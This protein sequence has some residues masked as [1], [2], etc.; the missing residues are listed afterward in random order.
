MPSQFFGL[1]IAYT[2]LLASNAALNTTSNNISNATTEGYSRQIVNQSAS[3]ALRTYTTYGCAGSGVDVNS[4]DRVRDVF[5]D[6][7]YWNNNSNVGKFSILD[8]YT[9]QIEDYFKDDETTEGFNTIFDKMVSNL[10]ELKKNAGDVPTKQQFVGSAEGLTYYFNTMAENLEKL[11]LEINTQIQNKIDMINSYAAEIAS[12]NKQINV[13]ELTG[14][15]ANELRDKRDS[16]LD[17]LSL[18][19]DVETEEI[20]IR[21]SN[22]LDRETGGNRYIVKIAGGQKLVDTNE[23]YELVCEAKESY[24]TVNQSDA[25]GLYDIYFRDGRSFNIYSSVV[26]GEL[27]GLIEM[28]DGNNGEN[29]TG[30]VENVYSGTLPSGDTRTMIDVS[31]TADY[32]K[33]LNACILSPAGGVITLGNEVYCYDKFSVTYDANGEIE[34]YTFVI[35]NDPNK[36]YKQPDI[37]RIGKDAT[38]GKSVDYQ[39]I[40]Y[41]QEQLNEW[42]RIFAE[43]FNKIATTPGAEDGEGNPA[44]IFFQ[45][46]KPGDTTQYHFDA[47]EGITAGSVLYSTDDSYFLLTAKN[48]AVSNRIVENAN[49]FATHT[50]IGAGQ[51][52]YDIVDSLI[53]MQEDTGVAEFRGASAGEF[54]QCVLADVALNANDAITFHN[55]YTGIQSSIENQRTSIS[56]VDSDEEAV[57]LVKYQ[58]AYNLASQVVQV[59]TEVYDRLILQT[60]V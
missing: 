21:D 53:K 59:L 50:T 26:G 35:S 32:L 5:Y 24:E 40:P 15:T 23:Y 43:A 56:G 36:N 1:N 34:K 39:G 17:E 18:I 14:I 42:V 60:G 48:F 33:D 41:Y 6:F 46:D 19:V 20:P 3:L 11:Q 52:K 38:V 51:D 55:N 9:S 12:L 29:F 8:E 54:L 30:T 13:I 45:A 2:G 57:N 22:N 10:Q 4:I 37:G 7:K 28:R 27:K 58:H 31:I 49:L 44:D 25:V 47:S 16:I